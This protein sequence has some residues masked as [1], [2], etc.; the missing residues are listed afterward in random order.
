MDFIFIHPL[1]WWLEFTSLQTSYGYG[2]DP[3]VAPS[4]AGIL[5]VVAYG[6]VTRIA[7]EIPGQK[8]GG[9]FIWWT[10]FFVFH[11]YGYIFYLIYN[12]VTTRYFKR[13]KKHRQVI[14][15]DIDRAGVK[16][17][18]EVSRV[19]SNPM[20]KSIYHMVDI[21]MHDEALELALKVRNRLL[22]SRKRSQLDQIDILI[23]DIQE[24]K[25]RYDD[26]RTGK[27]KDVEYTTW[28]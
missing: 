19:H 18:I 27:S 6:L 8:Q 1:L 4:V 17:S 11:I 2:F 5:G 22:R 16:P 20:T 7:A 21:G 24:R 28:N 12:F 15:A 13:V 23:E 26:Y 14:F 10:L 9:T 25:R 3:G